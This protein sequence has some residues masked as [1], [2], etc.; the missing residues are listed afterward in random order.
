MLVTGDNICQVTGCR[1]RGAEMLHAGIALELARLMV[2]DRKAYATARRRPRSA[3]TPPR[4]RVDV[5]KPSHGSF[6]RVAPRREAHVDAPTDAPQDLW[7][8]WRVVEPDAEYLR[9]RAA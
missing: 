8:T 7:L 2:E 3:E 5:D 9:H 4:S 1:E 6:D